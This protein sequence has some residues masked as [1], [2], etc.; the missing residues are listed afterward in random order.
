L[1]DIFNEAKPRH[2]SEHWHYL[3]VQP[4]ALA[5]V[6]QPF[7]L[8][9]FANGPTPFKTELELSQSEVDAL[10]RVFRHAKEANRQISVSLFCDM[11]HQVLA[12]R[13]TVAA[14]QRDV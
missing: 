12:S 14:T 4:G 11:F 8:E 13:P 1:R 5:N 9:V 3:V 6:I 2:P 10:R 7:K